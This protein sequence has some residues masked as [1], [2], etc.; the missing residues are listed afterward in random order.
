MELSIELSGM[1][2]DLTIDI[3]AYPKYT[4]PTAEIDRK[5][6]GLIFAQPEEYEETK[7]KI[8]TSIPSG[9]KKITFGEWNSM[10]EDE[11]G[12]YSDS[13]EKADELKLNYYT[14]EDDQV[15]L[16]SINKELNT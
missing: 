2:F 6:G 12:Y 7:Y 1:D 13:H 4:P 16:E 10:D 8:E 11:Q 3:T 15:I 9:F 14:C 5:T